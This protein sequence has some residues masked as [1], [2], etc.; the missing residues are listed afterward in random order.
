[1]ISFGKLELPTWLLPSARLRV[2]LAYLY[3]HGRLPDLDRPRRFTEWVQ[4]RK[5][6]DRDSAFA[7]LTDKM[8]SKD[9]AAERIGSDKVPR[10]LWSGTVLPERSPCDYPLV[11]KSNHG[12]NQYRI[13]RDDADW[14]EARR[15]SRGWLKP[16]GRWLD[17][18]HYGAARRLIMIEPMLG[19]EG[20]SLPVDYKVYVFGGRAVIVQAHVGRGMSHRW[21]QFDREWQPLSDDAVDLEAP[22]HLAE[23]LEAAEQLA[24]G[25]DFLRVD[26]YDVDGQLWFGE[27]CL[28]PGSGL[29]PF[30]P[31]SLDFYLGDLWRDAAARRQSRQPGLAAAA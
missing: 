25:H 3:S 30:S 15:A 9:Y 2:T 1:M 14:Q 19:G 26:F 7:L 10:T 20:A 8:H 21:T 12:S 6:H 29:D 13:V 31:D 4:H 18:W 28:Y 27:F 22:E 17:E 5:L 24:A 16:Y 23:M 11:V